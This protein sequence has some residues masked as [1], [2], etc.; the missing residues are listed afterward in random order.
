MDAIVNWGLW[1][2]EVQP[3]PKH[4]S[5]SPIHAFEQEASGWHRWQTTDKA[6]APQHCGNHETNFT[7]LWSPSPTHTKPTSPCFSCVL[8]GASN[9]LKLSVPKDWHL[10]FFKLIHLARVLSV[11]YYVTRRPSRHLAFSRQPVPIALLLPKCT[12]ISI[13]NYLSSSNTALLRS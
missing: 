5:P 10:F 7:S 1:P 2:E 4:D 8:L 12:P 3:G 11:K 9:H 13:D 6:N